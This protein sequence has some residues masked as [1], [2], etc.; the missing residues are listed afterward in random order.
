MKRTLFAAAGAAVLIATGVSASAQAATTPAPTPT[1]TPTAKPGPQPLRPVVFVHGFSGSGNQYVTQAKRFASNGYPAAFVDTLDYDSTF[2]AE[3]QDQ[4]F[5]RLDA[6]IDGLKKKARVDK[7]DL[8]GH[9]LGTFLS[10]R[11]LAT[12]ER[13]A[14]VAHYV[15]LD[16][17][18]ATALPGGVP[19]LAI[20]G[21]GPATRTITG[22]KN[23]YL[24][25]QA[26]TQTVSSTESFTEQ[27]AFFRGH[28]PRT[29]D[30]LPEAPG[31]TTISG[32]AVLFPSNVGVKDVTLE[33]YLVDPRTGQRITK[34]PLVKQALSGDG[35]FGPYPAAGGA[36]YEMALT[37]ATGPTHHFYTQPIRRT[38]RLI[39][40]LTSEP[41]TGLDAVTDKS[42]NHVNLTVNRNKEWW[43]DQGAGSDTL[44]VNGTN[45][46]NAATA[47]RTKR[48][49]GVFAYD[50]GK[51]GVSNVAAAL[52]AFASTP[53]ISGT[54]LFVPAANPPAKTVTLTSQQRGSDGRPQVVNV[55]NWPSDA[56]RISVG[57][58]DYVQAR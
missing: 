22:A 38:D 45:I 34:R 30:V 28:K 57:F 58:N 56:H 44:S 4:V 20:W 8:V 40:L 55:P 51:D 18:P 19:T 2:K 35:S 16:G 36:S 23:V 48:A 6:Q 42:A 21:E 9:S 33:I 10:Q 49:I 31:R 27:Y 7:V 11:Y 37:R 24:S 50:A 32:R 29:T 43:G 25:D 52:P 5:A 12:P 3:T 14:R 15:N 17:A 54:D 1:A 41:G 13:A 39:R 46:L 47:P 26:H 53:F